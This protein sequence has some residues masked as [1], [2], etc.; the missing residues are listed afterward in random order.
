MR[1]LNP[2][3]LIVVAPYASWG[4]GQRLKLH[5]NNT[6]ELTITQ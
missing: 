2:V 1:V 5:H 3:K 4:V 6:A